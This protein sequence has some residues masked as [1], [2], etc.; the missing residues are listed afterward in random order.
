METSRS[1]NSYLRRICDLQPKTRLAEAA[2]ATVHDDGGLSAGEGEPLHRT[3]LQVMGLPLLLRGSSPRD[4][5]GQSQRRAPHEARGKA[6]D[7]RGLRALGVDP[8]LHREQVEH[9]ERLAASRAKTFKQVADE[10]HREQQGVLE[11][12]PAR[13]AMDEYA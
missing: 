1:A 11:Q 3:R 12:C 7:A 2:R 9:Q 10:W 13:R 5:L 4:G 8:I 6:Q